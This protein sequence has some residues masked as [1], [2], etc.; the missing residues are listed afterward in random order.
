MVA[1]WGG[2]GVSWCGGS[3]AGV[4]LWCHAAKAD[5]VVVA[6]GKGRSHRAGAVV[7]WSWWS[8]SRQGEA[9]RGGAAVAWSSLHIG[10]TVGIV[11]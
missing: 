2:V 9:L 7:S 6:R 11:C 8:W 3:G 4:A 1:R 5:R 10:A